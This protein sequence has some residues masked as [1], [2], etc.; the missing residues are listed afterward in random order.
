MR[1]CLTPLLLFPLV[2]GKPEPCLPSGDERPINEAL[3]RGGVGATVSLCPGSVHHL[4]A[5]IRFNAPRQTLTT[6]GQVGGHDRAMIIVQGD[7]QAV[8]I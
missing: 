6:S 3:Q 2:A 5:P 8:A 7:D 1:L 4:Y